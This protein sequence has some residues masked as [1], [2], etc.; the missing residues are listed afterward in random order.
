[1]KHIAVVGAGP[2]GLAA[3]VTAA[4]HGCHVTLVDEAPRPGGQ[5]YRQPHPGMRIPRVVTAAEAKRKDRLLA[6]FEGMHCR[7]DYRPGTTAHSLYPGPELQI[8]TDLSSERLLPDAVILATGLSERALP[9]PN[10]TL[11]GIMY[12]G[13][14]Q[15]LLKSQGVTP[16][17]LGVIAGIGPLP[18]AVGAQLA[19]AGAKIKEVLL[20]HS[21][22]TI[23]A[24]PAALWS[25]REAVAD[26]LSYL[27]WLS[28]TGVRVRHGIAP[29]SADGDDKLK[30]VTF[31]RLDRHGKPIAGTEETHALDFLGINFGFTANSELVRMAGAECRYDAALGGWTPIADEHGQTS[32]DRVFV[33]GDGAG[34]R[35]VFVAEAEGRTVGAYVASTLAGSA[36]PGRPDVRRRRLRHM[37]FQASL[38]RAFDVPDDMTHLARPDT[39]VCRCEGVDAG[40]IARAVSDGHCTLDAIKRNTRAGMGWCGGRTCLQNVAMW[41]GKPDPAPMRARPVARPVKLKALANCKAVD[42]S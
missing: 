37:K 14:L 33:A 29:I 39:I 5:L 18:L 15:A 11:P 26:G 1:M 3:A 23:A 21:P 2:A 38:R 28:K 25:G 30:S 20:L 40:R 7:I 10:W 36:L 42:Q 32:L 13:G 16:R 9:F 31:A 22:W 4:G 8:A 6:E 35:G 24:S 17:G 27:R 41:L 34:L 19:N 12:A